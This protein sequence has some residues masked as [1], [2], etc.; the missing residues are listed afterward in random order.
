MNMTLFEYPFGGRV[1]YGQIG[2]FTNRYP[3]YIDSQDLAWCDRQFVNGLL[4]RQHTGPDEFPANEP[5][6]GLK[7]NDAEWC[8]DKFDFLLKRG[9]R[10]MIGTNRI[11]GSIEKTGL[12]G[13]DVFYRTERWVHLGVCIELGILDCFV[14]EGKV[15]GTNFC[16][17][18]DAFLL[19]FSNESDTFAGGNMC[20]VNT[21][22]GRLGEHDIAGDHYFLGEWTNPR[23]PQPGR[24][25]PF[26]H[27]S[28][29]VQ[30]QILHMIDNRGIQHLSILQGVSH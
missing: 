23:Q 17:H 12:H 10:G 30:G 5:P 26:M 18:R 28:M 22:S 29:R 16:R 9:M 4:H 1:E 8:R 3:G 6:S 21:S 7:A 2:C 25:S 24:N 13:L 19:C 15:M 14:G 27:V 11:D 20:H